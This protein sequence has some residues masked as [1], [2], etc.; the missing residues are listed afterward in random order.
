[1]WILSNALKKFL[2]GALASGISAQQ[3]RWAGEGK[4]E[5][6]HFIEI[7]RCMCNWA[8]Q[9]SVQARSTKGWRLGEMVG[10]EQWSE[11]DDSYAYDIQQC[12]WY[13]DEYYSD[14]IGMR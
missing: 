11:Y 10:A 1:M 14:E 7:K 4:T 9:K 2:T 5:E 3:T 12:E 8:A 13:E 6:E